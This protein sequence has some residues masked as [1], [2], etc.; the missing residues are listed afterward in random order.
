MFAGAAFFLGVAA[1]SG[2]ATPTSVPA[3]NGT[4]VL[5]SINAVGLPV[6]LNGSVVT[7]G[8]VVVRNGDSVEISE[9]RTTPPQSGG[10]GTLI[11]SRGMWGVQAMGDH[12]VLSP[13]AVGSASPGADTLYVSDGKLVIRHPSASAQQAALERIYSK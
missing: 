4:F 9:T 5:A 8:S 7:A 13:N 10:S 2:D 3:L 6:S 1:C 11:I 12:Y